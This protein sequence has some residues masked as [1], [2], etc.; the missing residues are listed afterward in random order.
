MLLHEY[1]IYKSII[2]FL[3]LLHVTDIMVVEEMIHHQS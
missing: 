2:V 3:I 1:N